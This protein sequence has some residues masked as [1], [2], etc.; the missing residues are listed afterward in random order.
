MQSHHLHTVYGYSGATVADT[1]YLGQRSCVAHEAENIYY[2]TL[3]RKSLLTPGSNHKPN[4][5][6]IHRDI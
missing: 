1:E 3:Y 4:N 6:L 5:S 2:L